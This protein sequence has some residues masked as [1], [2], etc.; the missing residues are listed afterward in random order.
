MPTTTPRRSY[1][2]AMEARDIEGVAAACAPDVVLHSPVSHHATF[3]GR[4]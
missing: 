2:E 3:H 4:E 1:R